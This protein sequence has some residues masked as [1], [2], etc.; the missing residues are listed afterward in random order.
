MLF[1]ESLRD[2]AKTDY[3]QVASERGESYHPTQLHAGATSMLKE[4]KG[5][6][7]TPGSV[8]GGDGRV[9]TE[10]MKEEAGAMKEDPGDRGDVKEDPEGV[11]GHPQLLQNGQLDGDISTGTVHN[12][13]LPFSHLS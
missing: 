3:R 8:A 2:G 6:V 9:K 7:A 5:G 10:G 12:N 1:P 13:F 4:S 11:S